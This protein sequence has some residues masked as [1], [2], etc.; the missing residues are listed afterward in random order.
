[1]YFYRC[2]NFTVYLHC[3]HCCDRQ[4]VL[5]KKLDDD[6][7]DDDP[8]EAEFFSSCLANRLLTGHGLNIHKP[9]YSF[10]LYTV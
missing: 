1:L 8:N 5:L 10:R 9:K 3:K 6:D 4:L 7:D 2:I